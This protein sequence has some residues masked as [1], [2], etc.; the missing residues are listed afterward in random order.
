MTA[1]EL[2]G[3]KVTV[4]ARI[5]RPLAEGMRI[6]TNTP[7]EPGTVYAFSL[8]T[9]DDPRSIAARQQVVQ[10]SVQRAGAPSGRRS[11]ARPSA[12]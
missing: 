2:P 9:N 11:S 4:D 1:S 5:G 3:W 10:S 8:F 7:V 12:A 6:F